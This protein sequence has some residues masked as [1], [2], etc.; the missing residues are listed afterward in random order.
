MNPPT[1][2]PVV[3]VMYF[4]TVPLE[5]PSPLGNFD[6]FELSR[7]RADSQAL[8]ASTTIFASTRCSVRDTLSMKITPLARPS[9]P[10][11]TSRTIAS[12]R[13][14]SLP[15]RI[16]GCSRTLVDEKFELTLQ[17]RLHWPQ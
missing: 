5:L 9:D 1:S 8:A 13:I 11:V 12:V 15:V 3:S 17:P 10:T 16:A 14:V 2:V 4:P 6:D 7:I